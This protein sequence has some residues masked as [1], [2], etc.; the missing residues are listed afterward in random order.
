MWSELVHV[1]AQDLHAT[2]V[3]G[4]CNLEVT[5]AEVLALLSLGSEHTHRLRIVVTMEDGTS[6]EIWI[7]RKPVDAVIHSSRIALEWRIRT[8]AEEIVYLGAVGKVV[9]H[10]YDTIG[11]VKNN[12]VACLSTRRKNGYRE[13]DREN[14]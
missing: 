12:L 2:L 13:N 6:T 11:R 10:N 3:T 1:D 9:V 14:G 4:H 5:V 7:D 8:I